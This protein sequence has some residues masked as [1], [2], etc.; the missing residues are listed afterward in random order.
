MKTIVLYYAAA[1]ATAIAGILHLMQAPNMLNFNPNGAILF[2]A[3]GAAQVF[4]ALPMVRR[5]GRVWYGVGIGGTI[6][7]IAIWV[8]TRFPGNPITGNGGRVSDMAIAIEVLQGIFIGFAAA[9]LVIESRMR[10]LDKK[11]ASEST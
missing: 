7:F 10:R 6:V 1:A 5:W 4:W 9:I 11:T 2:F 3:G 8:I